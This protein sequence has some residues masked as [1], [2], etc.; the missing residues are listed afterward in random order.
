MMHGLEARCPFLDINVVDFVRRIP[1]SFKLRRGITKY[2]LKEAVRG[3]IPD[4]V[5]DRPKKGF[6]I[7]GQLV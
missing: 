2:I 3:L 5:I 6:G 1:S 7:P 4:R